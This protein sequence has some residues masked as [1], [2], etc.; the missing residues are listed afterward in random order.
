MRAY[1]QAGGQVLDSIKGEMGERWMELTYSN[2]L[3]DIGVPQY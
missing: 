3:T 2:D 1:M